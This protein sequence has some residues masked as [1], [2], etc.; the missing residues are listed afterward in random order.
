M[1]MN[2]DLYVDRKTSKREE[3]EQRESI[4]DDRGLYV[5]QLQ[6]GDRKNLHTLNAVLPYVLCVP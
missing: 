6:E 5:G 3:E 4:I 2:N 1:R